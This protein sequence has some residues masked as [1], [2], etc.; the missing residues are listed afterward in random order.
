MS[1]VERAQV[2]AGRAQ[3]NHIRWPIRA[4]LRL[5]PHRIRGGRSWFE[6]KMS[7]IRA[8][9]WWHLSQPSPMLIGLA[10]RPATA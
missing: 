3:R 10:Q 7:I 4:F 1:G 5:D 8:A 9:V 2:R 6:T